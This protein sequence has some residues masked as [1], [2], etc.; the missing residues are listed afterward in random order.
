[1]S[2]SHGRLEC[3]ECQKIMQSCKCMESGKTVEYMVCPS[4]KA[5]K[6][7]EAQKR[8]SALNEKL[9]EMNVLAEMPKR[10]KK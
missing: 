10:N 2:H 5:E 7:Y 3:S 1:M 4:C 6:A 8:M 9:R